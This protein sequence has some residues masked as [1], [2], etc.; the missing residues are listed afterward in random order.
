LTTAA[1]ETV[2]RDGTLV[3]VRGQRWVVSEPPLPGYDENS[4]LLTLQ[5]VEDGRYGESLQVIWEVEPGRKILPA[6]SYRR[7]SGH[8]VWPAAWGQVRGMVAWGSQRPSG[9]RSGCGESLGEIVEIDAA[10]VKEEI[11]VPA[12]AV[13]EMDGDRGTAAEVSGRGDDWG[14]DL[15][16]GCR[17]LGQDPADALRGDHRRAWQGRVR[18]RVWRAQGRGWLLRVPR[19]WRAGSRHPRRVRPGRTS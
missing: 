13:P 16:C 2:P 9:E 11:Q 5:S 12:H 17:V 1:E 8:R 7:S 18:A 6:G 19:R 3:E 15:P 4:T 14:Q 10:R